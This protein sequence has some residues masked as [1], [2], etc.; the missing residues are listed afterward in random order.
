MMECNM[1]FYPPG[2]AL[3]WRTL[4]SIKSLKF[5][6]WRVIGSRTLSKAEF[7]TLL[8]Q[9][10][11]CLN[12]RPIAALNDDSSDLSALTSGHFLIGRPLVSV[13]ENF[14]LEINANRL[15]RWQLVQAMQKQIWRSWSKDYLQALQVRNKW[16]KPYPDVEIN[17][18]V[19]V[20]NPQLPPSRWELA[21]VEQV[22]PGSHGRVRVVILSLQV[23]I[24]SDQWLKSVNCRC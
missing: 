17:D 6:L 5:Y 21:R 14:I 10:E 18:L 7:A 16:T 4:R 19:I 23:L 9:I 20:R 11:A 8:C 22:H 13:R 3:F 15:S 2:C 12:S 24:I 1:I